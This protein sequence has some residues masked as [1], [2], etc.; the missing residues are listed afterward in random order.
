MPTPPAQPAPMMP[1]PPPATGVAGNGG[2]GTMAPN[3]TVKSAPPGADKAFKLSSIKLSMLPV[4]PMQAPKPRVGLI[5]ALVDTGK[6]YLDGAGQY[7][8]DVLEE[9]NRTGQR[10]NDPRAMSRTPTSV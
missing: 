7:A 5:P 8:V 9:N 2:G 3:K 4:P 1:A 6:D 10:P